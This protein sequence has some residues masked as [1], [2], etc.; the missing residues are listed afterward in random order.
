M[1]FT[2]AD[3]YCSWTSDST[4]PLTSL[5]P[6]RWN[7]SDFMKLRRSSFFLLIPGFSCVELNRAVLEDE[8]VRTGVGW[9]ASVVVAAAAAIPRKAAVENFIFESK[10]KI[11]QIL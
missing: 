8:S 4:L 6:R 7:R 5:N 2:R 1:S 9:N 10:R 3:W 11:N